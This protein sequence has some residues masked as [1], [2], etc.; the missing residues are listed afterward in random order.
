MKKKLL[1]KTYN[2]A[3]SESKGV[4]GKN[5]ID[6]DALS[7]NN[8]DR[9]AMVSQDLS[10]NIP[11]FNNE[12]KNLNQNIN[13]LNISNEKLTIMMQPIN[14][15]A[16]NNTRNQNLGSSKPIEVMVD[17][18]LIPSQDEMDIA[19]LNDDLMEDGGIVAE[20]TDISKVQSRNLNVFDTD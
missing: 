16:W 15:L 20:D 11:I 9:T 13:N 17:E 18:M 19:I 7:V 1:N 10:S 6:L 2:L 5:Q 4:S 12:I 8:T 3:A 14:N